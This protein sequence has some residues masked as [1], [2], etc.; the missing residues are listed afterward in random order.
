MSTNCAG[1]NLAKV[2]ALLQEDILQSKNSLSVHSAYF[3]MED[4][5]KN[6]LSR[7]WKGKLYLF[8]PDKVLE[9]LSSRP[10]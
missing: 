10:L 8:I 2:S 1:N 5:A 7:K 4:V 9:G 6:T 3:Y